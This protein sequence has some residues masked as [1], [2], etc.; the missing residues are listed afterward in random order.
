[1][2]LITNNNMP[3]SDTKESLFCIDFGIDAPINIK[4]KHKK[5]R[6][7]IKPGNECPLLFKEMTR[8]DYSNWNLSY[9]QEFLA[10]RG[11]TKTGNKDVLVTNA[12]NA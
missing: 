10:D 1:M 5:S 3:S 11:I 7:V 9:L 6:T 8:K 4:V 12:H 2:I